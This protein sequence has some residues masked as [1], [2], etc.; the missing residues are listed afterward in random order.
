MSPWVTIAVSLVVGYAAGGVPY[1][2]VVSRALGTDITKSGSGNIG[3]TNVFRTLGWR[4]A[5]AVAALDMAKG[6]LPAALA[7]WLTRN[8]AMPAHPQWHQDLLVIATGLAAMAGHMYSPFFR[9]RGGKGVATGAGVIAV[10]MP[11]VFVL[12]LV[13]FAIIVA[14]T[15]IVSVGSLTIALLFPLAIWVLYPHR[16][17]LFAFAALAVPLVFWSH[18][19]N[20]AR[21]VRHAEPRVTM[22]NVTKRDPS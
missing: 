12:L 2:V 22:G 17:A 20:L 7:L 14:A 4:P 13:L 19:A 3:A 9:L 16:P 5:L 15:R 10:L 8:W 21:I 11:K 6:A 1:G 18:R